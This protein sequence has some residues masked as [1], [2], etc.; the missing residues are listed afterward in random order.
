[1]VFK[2]RKK[3]TKKK[4]REEKKRKER[5]QQDTIMMRWT[6]ANAP[7]ASKTDGQPPGTSGLPVVMGWIAA[8]Q[9]VVTPK[10]RTA[11]VD[12]LPL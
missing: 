12:D 9:L 8:A 10:R 5:K 11:L 4:R 6:R 2:R 1:M 3:G 7:K